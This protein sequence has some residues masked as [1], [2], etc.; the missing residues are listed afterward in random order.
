M[1]SSQKSKA[2]VTPT[3]RRIPWLNHTPILRQLL[4]KPLLCGALLTSRMNPSHQSLCQIL[5]NAPTRRRELTARLAPNTEVLPSTATAGNLRK[6]L[7]SAN[8]TLQRRQDSS[9]ERCQ[10]NDEERILLQRI[11]CHSDC[12]GA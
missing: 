3:S 6:S 12:H 2:T 10:R 11:I 1:F 7:V 4:L 9:L 5:F 8:Y